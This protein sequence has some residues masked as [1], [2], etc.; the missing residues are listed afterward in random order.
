MRYAII[1][2]IHANIEALQAVIEH[3][4]PQVDQF[5]CLG[6][7]VGYN[8]S[9]NEC[10]QL[11]RELCEVIIVGNH[12][13]ATA[14][15]RTYDD[16]NSY[17]QAA[18]D[19]TKTQL[20]AEAITFLANLTPTAV[21]GTHNLAAHGSPRHTDEYLLHPQAIQQ[22]FAYL[23]KKMPKIHCCFVGHTH[24][25]MIW[26]CSEERIVSPVEKI[27]SDTVRLDPSRR[28]II[29][30]GSVGQP[31]HGDPA[32]SYLILDDEALTAT[33]CAVPYDIATTQDKIYDALL[34]IP[35]AERL[36]VGR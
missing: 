14:G 5:V 7:I 4:K 12:D 9:P 26:Q 29:N 19:W 34:P 32:S 8:A 16:F 25:P 35:L 24:V 1:S 20:D 6:D 13:Q 15:T 11:M 31:R 2:D 33:F 30:P 22:N 28:Y 23:I 18:I 21:F 10:L 3:A 27:K 36:E 17:A